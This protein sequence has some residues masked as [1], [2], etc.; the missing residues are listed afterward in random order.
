L[1]VRLP[2]VRA[3]LGTAESVPLPDGSVDVITCAQAWHWVDPEQGPP[4]CG[5]LLRP[6]GRLSLIW[7]ERDEQVDWVRRVWEPL[8]KF[9]QTGTGV[10]PEGWEGAITTHGPFENPEET[11]FA[12]RQVVDRA[13]VLRLLTSR[14][15]LAVMDDH[16]RAQTLAEVARILDTHPETRDREE[17]VLP[18]ET[19][20]FRWTRSG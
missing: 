13:H 6:G 5:R 9:G 15:A 3:S 12:Y 14:S 19:R 10:L 2:M 20:C 11:V 18:Y 16:T 7:N 8:G 1:T 17:W 4:E